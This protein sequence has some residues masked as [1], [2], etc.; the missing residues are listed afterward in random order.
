MVTTSLSKD[1]N[2]TISESIA[3][4]SAGALTYLQPSSP[5]NMCVE[6]S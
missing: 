5:T 2:I 6:Y 3:I 4:T 1:R